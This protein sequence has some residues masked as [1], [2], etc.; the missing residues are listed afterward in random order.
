MDDWLSATELLFNLGE[1]KTNPRDL[2]NELD[3]HIQAGT[4]VPYHLRFYFNYAIQQKDL[5]KGFGLKPDNRHKR[6]KMLD[7]DSRIHSDVVECGLPIEYGEGGAFWYVGMKW[8]FS[9]S[10]AAKAYYRIVKIIE[11]KSK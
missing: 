3:K 1:G 5:N 2:L 11:K 7:R 4:P 10:T 9:E 8:H 6:L